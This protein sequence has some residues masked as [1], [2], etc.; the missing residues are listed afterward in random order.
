MLILRATFAAFY[1]TALAFVAGQITAHVFARGP[2]NFRSSNQ[3]LVVALLQFAGLVIVGLSLGIRRMWAGARAANVLPPEHSLQRRADAVANA[4]VTTEQV[5]GMVEPGVVDSRARAV[6][7][8]R[9]TPRVGATGR[10]TGRRARAT[11][12]EP[13]STP[14]PAPFLPPPRIITGKS[15][16]ALARVWAGGGAL[17]VGGG[18][19]FALGG[20]VQFG[21]PI[22]VLLGVLGVALLTRAATVTVARRR[23]GKMWVQLR[24][25]PIAP[26]SELEGLV[27]SS[28]RRLRRAV[29]CRKPMRPARV[30]LLCLR[31][32]APTR[33]GTSMT[34]SVPVW[35]KEVA[36][37]SD[38][39]T[40]STGHL[41]IPFRFDVPADVPEMS[42]PGDAHPIVWLLSVE[43]ATDGVALVEQ[44]E[45]PI[46]RLESIVPRSA[47]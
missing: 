24:N 45:L 1:V 6:D 46:Y 7:R 25:S 38:R 12:V 10:P 8:P 9:E 15:R 28:N 27:W 21:R 41:G 37:T 33:R 17:I 40:V 18:G 23:A 2:G 42:R 22:A 34:N 32:P 14:G 16:E 36:V 29:R 5:A 13:P 35:Q 31:G 19:G 39:M 43:V 4:D 30:R 20:G 47:A 26:G 11:R 3:S 44:F